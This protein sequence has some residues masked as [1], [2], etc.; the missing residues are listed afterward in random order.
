MSRSNTAHSY[1]SVAKTF[2]WLTALLI[3]TVIPLGI[4]AN[5]MGYDTS[6]QLA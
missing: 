3:I 2:H 6:E 1:G 4:I 5:D